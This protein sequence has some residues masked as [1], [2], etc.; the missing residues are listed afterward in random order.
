MTRP[1]VYEVKLID[2]K[3]T[4]KTNLGSL[5]YETNFLFMVNYG[6]FMVNFTFHQY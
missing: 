6:K 4:L 5:A 3:S 1:N 2:M